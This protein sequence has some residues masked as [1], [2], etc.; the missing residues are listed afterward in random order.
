M[1]DAADVATDLAGADVVVGRAGRN[2]V[3]EFVALRKRGVVVPIN[4]RVSHQRSGGRGREA[5]RANPNL[6]VARL[7]EGYDAFEQTLRELNRGREA[8]E[9]G[10][11]KRGSGFSAAPVAAG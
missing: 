6:R 2:L 3:S 5:V 7:S 11:W 9:L 8:R 4:G 1:P 10:A